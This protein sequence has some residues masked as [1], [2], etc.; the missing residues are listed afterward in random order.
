MVNLDELVR[1][2]RMVAERDKSAPLTER[3]TLGLIA[4]TDL[5]ERLDNGLVEIRGKFGVRER[6]IQEEWRALRAEVAAAE[7]HLVACIRSDIPSAFERSTAR[8]QSCRD[9]ETPW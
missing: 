2:A 4:S 1:F 7:E 6:R 8:E 9:R 5:L 3:E